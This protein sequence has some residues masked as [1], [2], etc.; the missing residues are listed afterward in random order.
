MIPVPEKWRQA[1]EFMTIQ[2]YIEHSVRKKGGGVR[3]EVGRKGR[4]GKREI[5]ER[6]EVRKKKFVETTSKSTE[7][8]FLAEQPR[9][10]YLD[11]C[12]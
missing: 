11:K 6:E 2:G 12:H 10:I 5:G 3:E 8:E 4:D 1:C 9:N 7:K